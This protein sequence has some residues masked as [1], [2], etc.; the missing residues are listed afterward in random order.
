MRTED[1]IYKY[2]FPKEIKEIYIISSKDAVLADEANIWSDDYAYLDSFGD[3]DLLFLVYGLICKY[4]PNTKIQYVYSSVNC[5]RELM[6]KNLIVL[7]GPSARHGVAREFMHTKLREI[8]KNATGI[9]KPPILYSIK[10]DVLGSDFWM[11][12]K[13]EV[14][15]GKCKKFNDIT[16]DCRKNHE[17]CIWKRN[18]QEEPE[19]MDI[20]RGDIIVTKE[21]ASNLSDSDKMHKK[22]NN[23][24]GVIITEC[25]KRDIG[26]FAAFTNPNSKSMTDRVIMISGAHTFGGVG[27]F[28][29]FNAENDISLKNYRELDTF[30]EGIG[31]TDF[32]SFFPIDVDSYARTC[33][34]CAELKASENFISLVTQKQ[35]EK[36]TLEDRNKLENLKEQVKE[37]E[38]NLK[39]FIKSN[40]TIE[41]EAQKRHISK[42]NLAIELLSKVTNIN[43]VLNQINQQT[44]FNVKFLILQK[45]FNTTHNEWVSFK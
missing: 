35:V 26:V 6:D 16:F 12:I 31:G 36:L 25:I 2:W 9:D 23:S 29:T 24:E 33:N 30:L 41:G 5:Q 21:E 39:N 7:G 3:K 38:S 15:G 13:S 44:D 14:C 45:E 1:Y 20:K 42:K 22:I 28:K 4:Y 40:P 32:I 34:Q 17:I 19:F 8:Y 37:F 10:S 43:Q 18:E 27:A 11:R